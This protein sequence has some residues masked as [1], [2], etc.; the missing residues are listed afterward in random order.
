M[1]YSYWLHEEIQKDLNEGFEW[2]E[3]RKIGL[4]HKFPEAVEN[5]IAEIISHPEVFG[6]KGNPKFREALIKEFPY[7]IIYKIYKR[8]KEIFISTVHHTKKFPGKKYRHP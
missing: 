3:G 8:K 5:T 4:G 2:Y 1:S 7:I 6:S